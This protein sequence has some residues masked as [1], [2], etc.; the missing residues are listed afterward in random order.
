MDFIVLFNTPSYFFNAF[1]WSNNSNF[2]DL[3]VYTYQFYQKSAKNFENLLQNLNEIAFY[4]TWEIFWFSTEKRIELIH[5]LRV[6]RILQ[7]YHLFFHC[8]ALPIFQNFCAKIR[9]VIVQYK[10]T[11]VLMLPFF[12]LGPNKYF[13]Y[14]TE[15]LAA[16]WGIQSKTDNLTKCV[17]LH[18]DDKF[19][20]VCFKQNIYTG[21]LVA[22]W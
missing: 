16:Y 9:S 4:K 7:W 11:F 3:K 13:Q 5:K 20:S 22:F 17:L 19:W 21:I 14:N 2:S 15:I 12:G 18:L 6:P 10:A 1:L 8:K